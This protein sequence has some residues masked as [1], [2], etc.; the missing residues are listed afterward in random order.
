[1]GHHQV[2]LFR[3]EQ[4]LPG[5][6]SRRGQVPLS[7]NGSIYAGESD[8]WPGL[9]ENI[10]RTTVIAADLSKGSFSG[11]SRNSQAMQGAPGS[12]T[13]VFADL[14]MVDDDA[15][16]SQVKSYS[17][18]ASWT[19]AIRGSL[20]LENIEAASENLRTLG[21]SRAS[22]T[23]LMADVEREEAASGVTTIAPET[24]RGEIIA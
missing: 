2:I 17:P 4:K 6:L 1:M 5:I 12:T 24:S 19:A 22:G 13:S 10:R 23:S 16:P 15:P 7:G 14:T 21:V 11:E 3:G 20:E 8:P 9:L 18:R